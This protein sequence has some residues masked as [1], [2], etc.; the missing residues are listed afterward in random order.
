MGAEL[1]RRRK[2]LTSALGRLRDDSR[3]SRRVFLGGITVAVTGTMLATIVLT[4]LALTS[5][6]DLPDR[7][8]A[9]G[10]VLVGATLVLAA[11][12]A[13]VALL[14][15]AVSTGEPDLR[16]NV[17]F[18]P[19][20]MGNNPA[21]EIEETVDSS[22]YPVKEFVPTVATVRARNDSAY[23]ANNPAVIV[24]L[25]SMFFRV[26]SLRARDND[27]VPIEFGT[28]KTVT[29]VQ[30]DGGP[31]Y[32]V[33]GGSTRRLPDLP[34]DS[35]IIDRGKEATDPALSIEILAEGYRRIVS[36]PVRFHI[37]DKPFESG[38][39]NRSYPEWM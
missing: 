11:I 27:W 20:L 4:V 19:D 38:I 8:A 16:I 15:Y 25:E 34:M 1:S 37:Y 23:S 36:M 3:L 24:R 33:H 26:E 32:S 2:A 22:F 21:F 18:N 31:A 5:T 39:Y 12:A 35:L 10:D 30:W 9:A 14:A 17:M 28:R 29:A 13:I 6:A 7:L